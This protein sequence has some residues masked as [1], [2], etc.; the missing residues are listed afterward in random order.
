ME[1]YLKSTVVK[2][3]QLVRSATGKD[4]VLRKVCAPSLQEDHREAPAAKAL[5]EGAA[6]TCPWCKHSFSE[7]VAKKGGEGSRGKRPEGKSG[8]A[9]GAGGGKENGAASGAKHAGEKILCNM[10][11][12]ILMK[13]L[14]VA[15]MAR[16]DLLRPT[17]KLACFITNW[18]PACDKQ[19]L[20]LVPYINST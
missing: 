15:R 10:A 6:I 20:Q 14:Y 16:F 9:Y 3:Q 1:E 7:Q 19:L 2:C 5:G 11:A 8:A 13:I 17:C 4:P 18:S 12:S